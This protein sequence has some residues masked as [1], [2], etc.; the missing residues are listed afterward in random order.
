MMVVI[1]P[2]AG[3]SRFDRRVP[4]DRSEPF[5]ADRGKSPTVMDVGIVTAPLDFG[6]TGPNVYLENLCRELQDRHGDDLNLHLIHYREDDRDIYREATDVVIPRTP[7]VFERRVAGLDLDV[8]HYNYIP[9]KR[10]LVFLL[11]VDLVVSIHGDLPHVL[12]EYT[13]PNRRYIGV[14]I[15][16]LY[17]KIG[18]LDRIDAFLAVS[19]AAGEN[20]CRALSLPADKISTVYPGVDER[21]APVPDAREVI[22]NE[23]GITLPYVLN[24]NNYM[25]KKNRETL[26]EA[27]PLVREEYPEVRLVLAGGGWEKS[28]IDDVVDALSLE[29]AVTDLGYVP[30]EHL[31]A[32]YGGA[33]A[34]VNPTL[35]ETFGL[36]N[37]EAMACGCP[38][39]TSDRF[40]IPEIVGDAARLVADP[41]DPSAVADAT[42]EL[43][44]SE[45][46]REKL[47]WWGKDRAS[48]FSWERTADGVYSAYHNLR[49]T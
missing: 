43:L 26:L 36:P 16:R 39:V 33:E 18:L 38:V 5:Y 37:L 44:G 13:P 22:A 21:F 4:T 42:V 20:L 12:P 24:V 19:D 9:Y 32:L 8:L 27:L 6:P 29:E 47:S 46:V 15:Q 23:Y 28:G 31:P 35:H 2:S 25:R 48:E 10:P 7:G 40:S 34:L 49:D 30:D 11:D 17:G 41:L 45:S 1:R 14:P 3:A